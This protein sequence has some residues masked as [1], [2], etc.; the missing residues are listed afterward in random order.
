MHGFYERHEYPTLLSLLEN[1]KNKE[2]FYGGKDTLHSLLLEMGFKYRTHDN[3]RYILERPDI[4]QQRHSYLRAMKT[5]RESP[6]PRPVINLDETWCNVRHSRSRMWVDS[7]G[8]GGFKHS[9]GKGPRLIIVHAGGVA[10]WVSKTD[11]IFRS[12]KSADRDYHTEMNAEHF[13]SWFKYD[14]CSHIPVCSIIVMDNASY[15][16]TV[17][18][19]IPTKSS[20][21]DEMKHGIEH[22]EKDLKA[23]LMKKISEAKPTKIFKTDD[24]ARNFHHTVLR[25]PVHHPEL[26]PIKLAWS[27][28]KGYVTKH[29]KS[30]TLKE[31]EKLVPEGMS[32]VTPALWEKF[33]HHTEKVEDEYWQKDGLIEDI[34]EEILINAE[35]DCSDSDSNEDIGAGT[36]T[37]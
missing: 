19:K 33:C 1:L 3:K 17:V 28:V 24:I 10:G 20:N 37:N 9:V 14:L 36:C 27:V 6:H 18:E 7:D 11:F 22:D 35:D 4:V 25:L 32:M 34:V 5:N 23:D 30:F 29:N 12:K 13:L 2:L 21:K 8:T 15:H 16:N 31:V 26:N